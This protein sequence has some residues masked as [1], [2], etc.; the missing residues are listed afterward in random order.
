[1][2]ERP[3]ATPALIAQDLRALALTGLT[4]AQNPYDVDRYRRVLAL[5]AQLA[6]VGWPVTG[7]EVRR[8]YLRN[9]AHISPLLAAEAVV[10]RDE[11]VL[12][13]R[14][15]DTG[16]WGLP[17]GMAE[18]GESPAGSAE[19][20]LFEETGLR[21]R[22][23]RLLGVL[24]SRYAPNLHGLHIVA[25]IFLVEASG[26]P[27]STHEASEVGWF[28]WHG[29]P[30][31]QPGHVRSLA[32]AREAVRTGHPFFDPEPPQDW[33]AQAWPPPSAQSE[34][35]R[36]GVAGRLKVA[37]ARSVARIGGLWFLRG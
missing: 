1:M 10:L 13:M 19:R 8:A 18:V 32:V 29:L 9:L 17:G 23:V 7:L 28:D 26:E 35:G 33:V 24:D 21:G 3:A 14:R 37:L 27:H 5:S 6:E 31:L 2:S 11:R 36:G 34:S 22:A 4:Y 15:R 20:E 25:P 30:P 12:L 16:L